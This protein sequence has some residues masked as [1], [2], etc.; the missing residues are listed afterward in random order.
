MS[1]G[2]RDPR[3]VVFPVVAVAGLLLAWHFGVAW[4]DV[5][6]VILPPPGDVLA[7]LAER[8]RVIL[9]HASLTFAEAAAGFVVAAIVGLVGAV[10][11]VLFPPLGDAFY[12]L[13]VA[14][15]MVPMIALAPL[16]VVWFGTGFGSKVIMAAIVAF[17]PI[18][19]NALR[20]LRSV[21]PELHELFASLSATPGQVLWKLRLPSAV[22]YTFAALRVAAV[23]AVIGAV[24]AEFIGANAG[25][26]YFVKAAS[27]YAATDRMLAGI[28]ATA[29]VGALLYS[30]VL[31]LERAFPW[32]RTIA[33]SDGP[34]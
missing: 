3:K 2:V 27:Y 19:V 16:I 9:G 4:S 31:G 26:G 34:I 6:P 22:G 8:W 5:S 21:G 28:L 11:F 12:P 18:L 20:G 29:L 15:K 24:V 10:V 13:V 30:L 14:L 33:G 23:F 32:W 7:E 25:I 1:T 17:F